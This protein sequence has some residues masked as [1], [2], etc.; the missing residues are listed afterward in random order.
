MVNTKAFMKKAI[1]NSLAFLFLAMAGNAQTIFRPDNH[2]RIM[3]FLSGQQPLY[4]VDSVVADPDLLLLDPDQI[5]SVDVLKDSASTV[6]YGS[7]AQNGV[8]NIR[9]KERAGLLGLDDLLDMY[10]I[11]ETDR[12]LKVC[13]DNMLARNK[14]KILASQTNILRVE[15]I[16][17]I[18]WIS[19]V[20][21]GPEERY[22]NIVIKKW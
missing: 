1:L 11:P 5:L 15:V 7:M 3:H 20:E 22:I 12:N 9:M 13:I 2:R 6:L 18:C 21:P 14:H 8:I 16:K 19:P 17:D 10:H 4:I